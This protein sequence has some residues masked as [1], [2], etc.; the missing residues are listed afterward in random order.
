MLR[1]T[2]LAAVAIAA[3]HAG[4]ARAQSPKP[5]ISNGKPG[6]RYE[7]RYDVYKKWDIDS[8]VWVHWKET[9][10]IFEAQKLEGPFYSTTAARQYLA[11]RYG[12]DFDGPR[13]HSWYLT[14][15]PVKWELHGRYTTLDSALQASAWLELTN[16]GLPDWIT[17][18]EVVLVGK[19][20]SLRNGLLH[21]RPDAAR[22]MAPGRSDSARDVPRRNRRRQ[23]RLPAD[24]VERPIAGPDVG[25]LIDTIVC[26]GRHAPRPIGLPRSTGVLIRHLPLA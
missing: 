7:Y 11:D 20:T 10:D 19:D 1:T 2:L 18:I 17:K 25:K 14:Y 12:W 9:D 15:E 23:R 8:L 5:R 6:M 24:E 22:R 4:I 16:I 21:R 26:R 3:M 13:V